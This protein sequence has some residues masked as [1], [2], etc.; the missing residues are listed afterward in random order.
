MSQWCLTCSASWL[1]WMNEW[2]A[3]SFDGIKFHSQC[4][5]YKQE[6]QFH[7]EAESERSSSC[8]SSP[9][10]F[11]FLRN[12]SCPGAKMAWGSNMCLCCTNAV[13]FS[14]PKCRFHCSSS[15]VLWQ[16]VFSIQIF[17]NSQDSGILIQHAFKTWPRRQR[18]PQKGYQVE[19]FFIW[20]HCSCSPIPSTCNTMHNKKQQQPI[21]KIQSHAYIE[22]F[23]NH[24][25]WNA[26][27]SVL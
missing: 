21:L 2:M 9:G 11:W 23:C 12:M 17:T 7:D 3:L 18:V 8:W 15:V 20:H 27:N 22:A 6:V 19:H 5:M 16:V 14:H 13:H 25:I 1:T 4:C 24:Q 10:V 26:R